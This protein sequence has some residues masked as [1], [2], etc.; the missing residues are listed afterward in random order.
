MPKPHTWTGLILAAALLAGPA[1]ADG[2]D[3]GQRVK[4][5]EPLT[6][7]ARSCVPELHG[8]DACRTLTVKRKIHTTRAPAR[9]QRVIRRAAAPAASYDFTGFDGGV[10]AGI[11]GGYYGGG[12]GFIVS[13]TGPRFSGVLNSRAAAFT[14]Q[15]RSPHPAP[16]PKPNPC[17]AMR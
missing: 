9:K 5:P 14:F 8:H 13:G 15:H 4:G 1:L 11:D 16:R 7:H 17:C 3:T 6:P 12:G 10:G 2:K